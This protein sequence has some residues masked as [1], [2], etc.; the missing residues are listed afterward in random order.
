MRKILQ[1]LNAVCFTLVGGSLSAQVVISLD[2]DPGVPVNGTTITISGQPS[3][4]E[5]NAYM[6]LT[7]NFGNDRDFKIR[8]V[9][10]LI[11]PVVDQFCSGVCVEK[12]TSNSLSDQEWVFP[13][14]VAVNSGQSVEFK[15]GYKTLGNS[16]CAINDYYIENQFGTK[17]DSVRV[18]FVIGSQECFLSA[19][20]EFDNSSLEVYPNPS[21][22]MVTVKNASEGAS[23]E[24]LDML[25]KVA[26]KA[27][28][29]AASQ[30]VNLSGLPDGVYFYVVKDKRGNALPARKLIIR[31]Q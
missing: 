12:N 27:P 2:N 31:K 19:G 23:F 28:V 18:K 20:E 17:I 26:Y 25:G 3:D 1:I 21:S 24:V 22:G 15:P 16:F 5:V 7:N 10:K 30:K 8:I 29:S 9:K 11:D 6:S 14:E 13:I 4:I